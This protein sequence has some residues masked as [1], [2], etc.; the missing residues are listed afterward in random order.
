M[1]TCRITELAALQSDMLELLSSHRDLYMP[2]VAL[3]LQEALRDVITLHA[4]N[5]ITKC[6]LQK[7]LGVILLD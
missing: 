1:L 2:R 6:V 7:S 5:H 4:L 3:D